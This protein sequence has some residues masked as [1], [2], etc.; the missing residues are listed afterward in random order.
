M[1]P[2]L[3]KNSAHVSGNRGHAVVT[4]PLHRR[5]TTPTAH[6]MGMRVRSRPENLPA[7]IKR[8]CNHSR[9]LLFPRTFSIRML[10][11][12]HCR[13]RLPQS[14]LKGAWTAVLAFSHIGIKQLYAAGKL[15]RIGARS[16]PADAVDSPRRYSVMSGSSYFTRTAPDAGRSS[17][18]APALC[19]A[20]PTDRSRDADACS[21]CPGR[22][23][24]QKQTRP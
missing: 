2:A 15:Y 3:S 4:L 7:A 5:P 12:Q 6:V 16:S 10:S 9:H 20:D 23:R 18:G 22:I 24:A 11:A 8:W 13:Q 21:I 19:V 17:S 1:F 14:I